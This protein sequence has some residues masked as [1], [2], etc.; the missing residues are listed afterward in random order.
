MATTRTIVTIPEKE[1][2]W[3]KAFSKTHGMSMGEAIRQGLACLK[4]ADGKDSYK[5]LV[6]ETRGIWNQGDGLAYQKRI[7]AEWETR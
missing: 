6:Q 7:R 1:K 2:R 5:Q 3:L 4:A